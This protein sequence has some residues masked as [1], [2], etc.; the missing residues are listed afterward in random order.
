MFK[1]P[2]LFSKSR[3]GERLSAAKNI[4]YQKYSC[5]R[6]ILASNNRALEI[7]ADIEQTVYQDRPFAFAPVASDAERLICE[8]SSI[9]EDLNALSGFRY[10]ELF[11]V[12]EKIFDSIITE[13]RREKKIGETILVIP[14][15][16]ISLEDV[17]DVGGK[18]A[19]L[20]EVYNRANLP[21]PPGFSIT[22]Y[23]YQ[24]FMEH[25]RLT[26]L[27]DGRLHG[28]DVND[29]E[30]LAAVSEEIQK[31]ILNA[32]L[33]DDLEK[34]IL[35]AADH[36]LSKI[37]KDVRFSVRS[38]A[39]SEDSEASFAGQHSTVLNV[40]RDNIISAYREV[41]F[42]N[43][44]SRAIFYRRSRGFFDQDVSMSVACI[45]MVDA[46][47]SGVLYTVDPNDSRH[48]VIMINAVWGL[49]VTVVEGSASTD[50][51]QVD[52]MTRQVE[53][54]EI[55][56]KET[57]L[58][59]GDVDGIIEESVNPGL[60]DKA[61]LDLSQ[62]SMLVDYA[63]I[64]EEHYGFAL[65]IEWAID[66][67][68]K[69][70]ILQSRPLRRSQQFGEEQ[71]SQK[72]GSEPSQPVT[73]HEVLLRGGVSASDGTASGMAYVIQ[74]DHTL[75]HVP[76]GS[77]LIARQTSPRYVP[78]M[79]RIQAI[80]TD[81]GSVTGHMASVAR[82]FRLP[83]LVGTGNATDIIP[84]G[85][86]ITVDAANR[87]IYS[88]RVQEILKEKKTANPMKGSPVYRTVQAALKK[89]AP[90]NLIDPKQDS[91]RPEACRTIHDLIRFSHEMAM[92]E[93]FHL[94]ENVEPEQGMAILLKAGIPI[95]I[96]VI[97]LGKGL[98][99]GT[100]AKEAT[101][102][103]ILSA[104]FRSFMKG[105]KHKDILW[106]P[107]FGISLRG[108]GS[109]IAESVFR[110][111]LKEGGMGGPSYAI[112]ADRYLNMSSRMGYHFATLD[113]FSGPKINDN[114]INF[115]FKGGAA[116]IA[117]RS[118]RA[119]LIAM[120]LKR[121]GFKVEQKGDMV[122][123]ELKKF[124]AMVIEKKLDMLGRLL[125][126]VR[127]LD[128]VLSDDGEVDWYAEQFMNGNYNFQTARS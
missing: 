89:I 15:E 83:T 94:G 34:S 93:M 128:M 105:M 114:Y 75:H 72:T 99:V 26:E 90:L 9:I 30:G 10:P 125:A 120:I 12:S 31:H 44:N 63:L 27:I 73:S 121:L 78:L 126:S 33:P 60:R 58:K 55:A 43:F 19:N 95:K 2:R 47:V 14:L 39:S 100:M 87:T 106:S 8:V 32:E 97:D 56:V 40:S 88:G 76:S 70:Y 79:G 101:V 22:A 103:D 68:N 50:F 113:T 25:N 98:S 116:D 81:V 51:Y 74:S 35:H 42:S 112:I 62:I 28:V 80:V 115:Y 71:F 41:V 53:V 104:P 65:D 66:Q 4:F 38:S 110:D 91:F 16:R 6:S 17:A 127:L 117:R 46:K 13:L 123:A 96:Y 77:I 20:G 48:S 45:M 119:I 49:A 3:P 92:Q 124:E 5:F 86:E 21:V 69:L 67:N 24:R 36:L 61:C 122:R 1:L 109:I 37:G 64:L 57:L 111:P 85:A 11:P 52:K 7:I 107:H 84:Q 54:S 18:A 102:E 108:I 23:A 118:R 82:E 59:L 29:I